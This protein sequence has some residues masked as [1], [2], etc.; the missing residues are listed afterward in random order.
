MTSFHIPEEIIGV[1]L[2]VP[3]VYES[4]FEIVAGGMPNGDD[5]LRVKG[6]VN[7]N[8]KAVQIAPVL[9]PN[10]FWL[11]ETP[12]AVDD[13][14][15]S[16]WLKLPSGMSGSG[17]ILLGCSNYNDSGAFGN[18]VNRNH[19]FLLG[20][21]GSD[22]LQFQRQTTTNAASPA[23]TLNVWINGSSLLTL[24]NHKD[25]WLQLVMN[26]GPSNAGALFIDAYANEAYSDTFGGTLLSGV[27]NAGQYLH[28]GP[29][30]PTHTGLTLPW[31]IGKW[32]FHD[33]AL[34]W[35]E[36]SLMYN[37]MMADL[38]SINNFVDDFNRASLGDDYLVGASAPTIVTD[39]VRAPGGTTTIR[40][41]RYRYNLGSADMWGELDVLSNPGAGSGGFCGVALRMQDLATYYVGEYIPTS[42][43]FQIRKRSSGTYG[44]V[45]A[46]AVN[47]SALPRRIRFETETSGSDVLLRL[48]EVVG[49]TPVLQCSYTDTT[50]P[51]MSDYY[52]GFEQVGQTGGSAHMDNDNFACGR[53]TP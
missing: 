22:G 38:A 29:F 44:S 36:R 51:F 1:P 2:F 20:T 49:G 42:G 40:V 23:S 8:A 32:A 17:R 19:A 27:L 37:V 6:D 13:W 12:G 15:M 24:N 48:Y 25:R 5:C 53:L 39:F 28:L 47:A 52:A 14:A 3:G 11:G 30:G 4:A 35:T 46:S 31:E 7:S 33:H 21:S 43:T 50:S 41:A 34:S 18:S 9:S 26:F 16:C 10:I 45:L